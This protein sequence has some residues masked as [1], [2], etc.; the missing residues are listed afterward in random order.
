MSVFALKTGIKMAN[1]VYDSESDEYVYAN[2]GKLAPRPDG[3]CYCG[4]VRKDCLNFI[5]Y[6]YDCQGFK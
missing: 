5:A 6:G 3:H 1:I 4:S 2:S